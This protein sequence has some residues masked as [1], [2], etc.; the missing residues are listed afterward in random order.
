MVGRRDGLPGADQQT[1]A[2]TAALAQG[3]E[4][5]RIVNFMKDGKRL[6]GFQVGDSVVDA[7]AAAQAAKSP[8]AEAFKDT[9]AFIAGGAAARAEAEK[10]VAGAPASARVAMK[11]LRL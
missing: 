10:L 7:L 9:I 3:G 5:M 8:N 4:D 1:A 2:L 11:G 6:L